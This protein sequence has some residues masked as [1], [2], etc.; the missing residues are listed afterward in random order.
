MACLRPP[1]HSEDL[2]GLSKKVIKGVYHKIP[3]QYSQDLVN[4]I[5]V[6]LQVLPEKRPNCGRKFLFFSYLF[7]IILEELLNKDIV[8]SRLKE[9]NLYLSD[10]LKPEMLKTIKCPKNVKNIHYLAERLPPNN[11]NILQI[12]KVDLKTLLNQINS[13]TSIKTPEKHSKHEHS[14]SHSN[15]SISFPK[16]QESFTENNQIL[17]KNHDLLLV[18]PGNKIKYL[19]YLKNPSLKNKKSSSPP[20]KAKY[21]NLKIG[22]NFLLEPLNIKQD[23]IEDGRKLFGKNNYIKNNV[24]EV[25]IYK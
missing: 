15:P 6:L 2:E 23:D 11:Y 24:E 7:D 12:K 22:R 3:E 20:P 25:I 5:S 13:N 19:G 8:I 9:K 18:K 21:G 14:L 4:I 17:S 10:E 16:V 1:F